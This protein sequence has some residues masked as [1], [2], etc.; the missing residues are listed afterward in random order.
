MTDQ[1]QPAGEEEIT[2]RDANQ[3]FSRL[4]ARVERGVRFVVT[5]K[6]KPVARIAPVDAQAGARE[7]RRRAARERL[8]A[9]M[10][11]GIESEEGWTYAGDRDALHGRDV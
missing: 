3:G 2:V 5:K 10:Q 11:S 8:R 9:L 1:Q 4:I 6:G 7:Q